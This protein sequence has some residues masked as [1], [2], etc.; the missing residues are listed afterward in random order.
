MARQ[1][2]TEATELFSLG[3]KYLVETRDSSESKA[4]QGISAPRQPSTWAHL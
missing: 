1:E 2:R 3:K 4:G